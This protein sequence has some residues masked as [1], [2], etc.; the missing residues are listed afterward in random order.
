MDFHIFLPL[1][2]RTVT[3]YERNKDLTWNYKTRRA[4]KKVMERT[5]HYRRCA[6]VNLWPGHIR[7]VT[8][9]FSG[10]SMAQTSRAVPW[11]DGDHETLITLC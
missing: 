10:Q 1:F 8:G 11:L 6:L 3:D 9:G 2:L 4:S 7:S 5:R